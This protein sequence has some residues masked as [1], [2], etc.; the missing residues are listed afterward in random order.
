M[1]IKRIFMDARIAATAKEAGAELVEDY[2][3]ADVEFASTR[4][5]WT[6]LPAKGGAS[7]QTRVL[8]LA[9]GALSRLA[10]R[11]GYVS[12]PSE[13]G[14]CRKCP[15]MIDASALTLQ[16]LKRS[17][18]ARWAEIVTG[19]RPKTDFMKP[20]MLPPILRDLPAARC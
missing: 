7:Y 4:K 17:F 11:L 8:I 15:V 20:K 5:L 19:A 13:A 9:D 3:V 10:R 14:F 16:R 2:N 12:T 1:G 6:I 18:L